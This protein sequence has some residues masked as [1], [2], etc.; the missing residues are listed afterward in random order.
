MYLNVQTNKKTN[1][2]TQ[3]QAKSNAFFVLAKKAVRCHKAMQL[4]HAHTCS[5]LLECQKNAVLL[6][7]TKK[8]GIKCDTV[9]R[10]HIIHISVTK[11]P[12]RIDRGRQQKIKLYTYIYCMSYLYKIHIHIQIRPHILLHKRTRKNTTTEKKVFFIHYLPQ[13][14]HTYTTSNPSSCPRTG[15]CPQQKIVPK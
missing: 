10:T 9:Y 8:F 5:T 6:Y 12:V 3:L 13:S 7:W 14:A 4:R 1:Y 15:F 11:M 2:K